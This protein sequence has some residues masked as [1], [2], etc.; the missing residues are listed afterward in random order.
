VFV[1][2]KIKAR[3]TAVKLN[4][5]QRWVVTLLFRRKKMFKSFA[6]EREEEEAST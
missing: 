5:Y 3:V 6:A 4:Q 1:K 2:V